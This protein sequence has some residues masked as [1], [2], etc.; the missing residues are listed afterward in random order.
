MEILY[1]LLGVLILVLLGVF[2]RL[3][4]IQL[5]LQRNQKISNA[6]ND[7]HYRQRKEL[8]EKQNEIIE[9]MAADINQLQTDIKDIKYVSD[10]FHKYKLPDKKEREMLEQI[11]IDNEVFDLHKNH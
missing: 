4:S 7:D 9:E 10:I 2:I 11:E 8:L 3:S 1:I 6:Y 5:Q